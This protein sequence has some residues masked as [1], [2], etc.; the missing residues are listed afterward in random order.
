MAEDWKAGGTKGVSN[1]GNGKYES[2]VVWN[3]AGASKIKHTWGY[4]KNYEIVIRLETWVESKDEEK[5]KK[6]LDPKYN[7]SFKE[8]NRVNK[9]GRAKGG[10]IVE[11]RTESCQEI[12]VTKW[13]YGLV[14]AGLKHE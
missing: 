9:A 11:I 6:G 12:E 3:I 4:L 14:I 8:A 10:T 5:V 7:W 13:E 1:K 2:L